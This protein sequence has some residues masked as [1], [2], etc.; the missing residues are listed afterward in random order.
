[1]LISRGCTAIA[2]L[3]L[4]RLE[5]AAL[6]V[7]AL[8]VAASSL[9]VAAAA[10]VV[11]A[12]T[13]TAATATELLVVEVA[14]SIGVAAPLVLLAATAPS[15]IATAAPITTTGAVASHVAWC[16]AGIAVP[17]EAKAG[18]AVVVG[19]QDLRRRLRLGLEFLLGE[20]KPRLGLHE[21]GEG[22]HPLKK[23]LLNLEALVEPGDEA[24]RE[25]LVRDGGA[26]VGE[27]LSNT[28]HLAAVGHHIHVALYGV[29]ELLVEVDLASLCVLREEVLERLPG[30]VGGTVRGEDDVLQLV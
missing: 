9:M 25:F 17:V 26:D 10:A 6:V 5:G 14:W 12:S 15:L 20:L 18:S 29:L 1:L 28:F 11:T 30:G 23:F 8:V 13:T 3:L 7:S 19:V 2:L 16:A 24:Q 27:L 21:G 22:L 4:V